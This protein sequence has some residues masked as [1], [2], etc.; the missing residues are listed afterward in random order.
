MEKLNWFL[1]PISCTQVARALASKFKPVEFR[2]ASSELKICTLVCA[3]AR[4]SL[5]A[6][7]FTHYKIGNSIYTSS[8]H[9]NF[10]IWDILF[11]LQFFN[12]MGLLWVTI[13][14]SPINHFGH[15]NIRNWSP[16][17]R[18]QQST[19]TRQK[20]LASPIYFNAPKYHISQF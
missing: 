15:I 11:P 7:S 8:N 12:S 17:E 19:L 4:E 13:S 2:R 18:E 6:N 16:H 5:L 10:S 14:H 1:D 9:Y 20:S 3:H